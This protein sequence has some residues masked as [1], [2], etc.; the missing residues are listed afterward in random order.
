MCQRYAGLEMLPGPSVY[1]ETQ[2]SMEGE[3]FLILIEISQSSGSSITGPS[4]PQP[5]HPLL[6]MMLPYIYSQIDFVL[7]YTSPK[8]YSPKLK[9]SSK[10][11]MI[12]YL[13]VD[14]YFSE[15]I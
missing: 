13:V 9:N 8:L 3:C 6:L 14:N 2:Y 12:T 15:K 10:T 1:L 7:K 5:T 4:G 11:F